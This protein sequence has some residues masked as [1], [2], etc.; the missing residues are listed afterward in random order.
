[1]EKREQKKKTNT[2]IRLKTAK[3]VARYMARCI[4]RAEQGGDCGDSYKLVTMASMLLKAVEVASLEER[5]KDL[6]QRTGER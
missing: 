6:E 4:R 1:M 3:D 2:R 5:I